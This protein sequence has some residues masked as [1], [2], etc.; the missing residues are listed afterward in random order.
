MSSWGDLKST[1]ENA[2]QMAA[3]ANNITDV[4]QHHP[5]I[6]SLEYEWSPGRA[7]CSLC[8]VENIPIEPENCHRVIES[9]CAEKAQTLKTMVAAHLANRVAIWKYRPLV[10]PGDFSYERYLELIG[11][12]QAYDTTDID[13]LRKEY[14][15]YSS[16]Q[17]F[18]LGVGEVDVANYRDFAK[19]SDDYDFETRIDGDT[20]APGFWERSAGRLAQT[21]STVALAGALVAPAIQGIG[22]Y[23]FDVEYIGGLDDDAIGFGAIVPGFMIGLEWDPQNLGGSGL[24]ARVYDSRGE[25]H[26]YGGISYDIEIPQ[27]YIADVTAE[28]VRNTALTVRLRVDSSNGNVW[29]H[30][31]IKSKEW[32]AFTLGQSLEDKPHHM[33]G[34]VTT[35][36]AA[37]FGNFYA[38]PL[39]LAK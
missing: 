26:T 5:D 22:E 32:W 39:G 23:S 18:F 31:P 37:S 16:E 20:I 8:P 11:V 2:N 9:P 10:E 19:F 21:D 35:S 4:F 28:T 1:V 13:I 12:S 30:D 7:V 3:T 24:H 38:T 6:E 14:E 15:W 34:V 36:A 33:F 25:I 17:L 29:V 27:S